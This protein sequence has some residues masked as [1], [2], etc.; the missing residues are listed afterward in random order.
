[1]YAVVGGIGFGVLYFLS[2]KCAWSFC[3]NHRSHVSILLMGSFCLS[4]FFGSR[5]SSSLINPNNKQPFN[6]V[7]NDHQQEMFY[8]KHS[9]EVQRVPQM[10]RSMSLFA[11]ILF[12]VALLLID[13]KH[14]KNSPASENSELE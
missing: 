13:H 3:P 9:D 5:L 10:L 1:M 2:F 4:S 7:V 6:Y 14:E 8:D 12:S 11:L